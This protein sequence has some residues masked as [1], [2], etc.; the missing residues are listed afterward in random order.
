MKKLL[1]MLLNYGGIICILLSAILTFYTWN[2]DI[3]VPEANFPSTTLDEGNMPIALQVAN[4]FCGDC[5][6]DYA[7][8]AQ[9]ITTKG[10][11]QV[12]MD[13]RDEMKKNIQKYSRENK[14]WL[15]WYVLPI[16][17][18]SFVFEIWHLKKRRKKR[19]Q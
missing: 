7:A 8:D 17:A 3:S 9:E 13:L 4:F 11:K 6:T 2:T 18:L 15:G 19:D 5:A 12:L 1:E 16:L 14:E 10:A